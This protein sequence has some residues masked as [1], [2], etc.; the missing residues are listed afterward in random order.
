MTPPQLGHA[1]ESS[2]K[3]ACDSLTNTVARTGWATGDRELYGSTGERKYLNREER[4]R[5]L[6]AA[7]G[8]EPGPS[9]FAILMAWTGARVS[10]LLALTPSSFQID[11]G[12]VTIVTLKRRKFTV[13]EVPIPPSL[14]KRLD[15]HFGLRRLQ[16]GEHSAQQRLWTWHRVTAWRHIKHAMALA[17]VAG[18]QACPRGLRHGF[19]VG[20]LQSGVPLHLIQRWMGHARLSTTAIYMN[21]CGPE[22]FGFAERFWHHRA[23]PPA[24]GHH[25]PA[26]SY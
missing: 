22:E 25:G 16:R 26:L 4:A 2:R 19:G 15:Q 20:A 24:Q 11:T 13:R 21:V 3:S 23:S 10:E 1:L 18:K 8:L 5:F 6:A 14:I 17:H 12:V 9:L 7:N